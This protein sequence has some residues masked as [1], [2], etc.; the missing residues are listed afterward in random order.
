MMNFK[1]ICRA[2]ERLRLHDLNL[3]IV[4]SGIR[5]YPLEKFPE[6]NK[7]TGTFIPY[8]RVNALNL[9]FFLNVRIINT[10]QSQSSDP[11]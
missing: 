1:Q 8:Y 9:D 2:L 7:R 6:I 11:L 4:P 3:I 10:V 5:A